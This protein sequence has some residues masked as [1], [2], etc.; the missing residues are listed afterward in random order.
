[1]YVIVEKFHHGYSGLTFAVAKNA[2]NIW[3]GRTWCLYICPGVAEA[4]CRIC[5]QA[6]E[7]LH[8]WEVGYNSSK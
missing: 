7:H 1:M 4:I 3:E 8:S 2:V 5:P 6:V